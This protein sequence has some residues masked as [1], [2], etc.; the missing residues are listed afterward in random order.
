[1]ENKN[2]WKFL[3]KHLL[4]RVTQARLT[5]LHGLA[6]REVYKGV[7]N[8]VHPIRLL[9]LFSYQDMRTGGTRRRKEKRTWMSSWSD[10]QVSTVTVSDRFGARTI[11]RDLP[12]NTRKM[13]DSNKLPYSCPSIRQRS[14]AQGRDKKDNR[15]TV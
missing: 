9:K 12:P 1:M 8:G 11:E 7:M 15:R 14:Q 13:G 2:G 10:R 5:D 3:D 4:A 6:L